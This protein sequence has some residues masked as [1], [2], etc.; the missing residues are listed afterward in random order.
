MFTKHFDKFWLSRDKHIESWS[1]HS[2]ND[3]YKIVQNRKNNGLERHNRH[4]KSLFKGPH[5][6]SLLL[7]KPIEEEARNQ[8]QKV[9]NVD[10]KIVAPVV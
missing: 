6:S 3:E 2:R 7:V 10:R 5:P 8:V 1:I 4:M 9:E